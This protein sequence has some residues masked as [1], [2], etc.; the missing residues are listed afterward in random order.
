MSE[1]F[2]EQIDIFQNLR[3]YQVSGI[4]WLASLFRKN[5]N[6]ILADEMGL[7]KTIQVLGYFR[8]LKEECNIHGPHVII[9]PLSVI[10]SWTSEINRCSSSGYT[11]FGTYIHYGEREQRE[12]QFK[13]ILKLWENQSN[14]KD[15]SPKKTFLLFFTYD[16][17]IRDMDLLLRYNR[18]M[19]YH[20]LIIDEAHRLKNSSSVLYQNLIKLDVKHK[21]L[22]T[23]TPL[24]NT[25]REL[26]A[27]LNFINI[28]HSIE[29]TER[30]EATTIVDSQV[31]ERFGEM[32]ALVFNGMLFL[33][34]VCMNM[35]TL[36]RILSVDVYN[37]KAFLRKDHNPSS[38]DETIFTFADDE[39]LVIQLQEALKP[40]I[41]RRTK[42]EVCTELPPKVHI[43]LSNFVI[44]L[45]SFFFQV[46]KI[47]YCPQSQLQ[48]ALHSALR[49]KL[50]SDYEME[51]FQK[52][53][54]RELRN[55][56]INQPYTSQNVVLQLRKIC[57]HSYL[58][59]EDFESIPDDLYFQYLLE[60]SGKLA[61]LDRLLDT[62]LS[63]NSKVNLFDFF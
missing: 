15:G 33:P 61:V 39:N 27:L 59:L 4:E 5:R 17:A 6:G 42:E 45:I 22:L 44:D 11:D 56:H 48:K 54:P 10:N 30:A 53:I 37:A 52:D 46:E 7:G 3:G 50:E 1:R 51:Q 62:L 18:R 2:E 63:D 43:L 12:K 47:I 32:E 31:V 35:L 57:N 21:I 8:I 26:L 38:L 28:R 60:S 34:F 36:T 40:Y 20:S 58:F 41:L 13:R 19:R 25:V 55:I 29:T 14:I 24:Q 23:G 9:L 16:M 49:K